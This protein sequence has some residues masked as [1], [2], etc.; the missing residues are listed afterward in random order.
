MLRLAP[1]NGAI[2]RFLGSKIDNL[3]IGIHG[4]SVYVP[5]RFVEQVRF[6][7][8]FFGFFLSENAEI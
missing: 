3:G 8:F 5:K 4:I 2:P 7:L 1:K 6:F